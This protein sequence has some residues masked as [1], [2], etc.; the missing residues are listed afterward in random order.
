MHMGKLNQQDISE[1]E[2]ENKLNQT[3]TIIKKYLKMRKYILY[4]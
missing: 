3:K 2:M 4:C 1:T